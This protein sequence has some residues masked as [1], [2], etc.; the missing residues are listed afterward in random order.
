MTPIIFP[1]ESRSLVKKYLSSTVFHALE[2][3]ETD[4]GYTLAK[5]IHSGIKNPDSAIG[6]YAGDTQSYQTFSQ[7]FDPI[8]SQYHGFLKPQTHT[9]DFTH[10]ELPAIDPEGRYIKSTRVRVARNIEGFS[11]P[12]HIEL[13][14]RQELEKKI[15]AV[16]SRL[17]GDLK[18]QYYSLEHLDGDKCHQLKKENLIF[19][20]GDRFQ[21]AAGINSDFPKARG[22]FHSFDK[23]FITWVNEED[24]LRLISLEKTSD[25]SSVYNRLTRALSALNPELDFARDRTYG[26]LTSCPTNIGTSMRAGVHIQLERLAEQKERLLKLARTYHL[27]IRGTRG[28][29]TKVENAVFDISNRQRLG[30]TEPQI[31]ENLHRGLLAIIQV[32]KKL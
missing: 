22:I 16:L 27:Q 7:L 28:E 30:I 13:S 8:I 19:K 31:L 26:Y 29:K 17:K 32:E 5:A 12:C 24:H 21:D 6:I 10:L 14:Q 3:L 23:Q 20:R 1:E 25:V 2:H 4:S 11:F 18:G 9:S 15:I